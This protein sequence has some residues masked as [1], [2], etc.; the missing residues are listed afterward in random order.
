MTFAKFIVSVKNEATSEQQNLV[1]IQA[2]FHQ[3][4]AAGNH[5]KG[6]KRTLSVIVAANL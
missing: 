5:L 6:V 3:K 2:T 4:G 1:R